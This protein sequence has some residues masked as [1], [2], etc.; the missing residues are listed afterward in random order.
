MIH[1]K[2]WLAGGALILWICSAP[3]CCT[4]Q[5]ADGADPGRAAAAA[6]FHA[7]IRAVKLGGA[8]AGEPGDRFLECPAITSNLCLALMRMKQHASA[9]QWQ[10]AIKRAFDHAAVAMVEKIYTGSPE[11]ENHKKVFKSSRGWVSIS[12]GT[13][14]NSQ[15]LYAIPIGSE[16]QLQYVPGFEYTA[17]RLSLESIVID[18]KLIV[19]FDRVVSARIKHMQLHSPSN[20]AFPGN[21]TAFMQAQFLRIMRL[22][23]F[24]DGADP[25]GH[26][27]ER[28]FEDLLLAFDAA[29]FAPSVSGDHRAWNMSAQ[30]TIALCR[31][32][33]SRG[34][35]VS[36]WT[37]EKSAFLHLE[38]G[39]YI[40]D[41]SDDRTKFQIVRREQLAQ[42]NPVFQWVAAEDVFPPDA[43]IGDALRWMTKR[44]ENP[45]ISKAYAEMLR[46]AVSAK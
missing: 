31:S 44:I 13:D 32:T 15:S 27:L 24:E 8:M 22:P 45:D 6:Q 39:C 38:T 16:L 41:F 21:L 30:A 18:P 34:D 43:T 11:D 40:R 36:V 35:S 25:D 37:S 20:P 10:D 28:D 42:S 2:S 19:L 4:G 26:Y 5:A 7:F 14:D 12:Y 9:T 46:A 1:R 29:V 23:G 17:S 33:A 3:H